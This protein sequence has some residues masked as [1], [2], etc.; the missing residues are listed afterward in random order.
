MCDSIRLRNTYEAI[1]DIST[2]LGAVNGR[3]KAIIWIGGRIPFNP[4]VDCGGSVPLNAAQASAISFMH[5][6]A[7]RAATRNNVAIYSVD[8]LALTPEPG[9]PFTNVLTL[10]GL[11]ALRSVA[12]DTGGQA[13]VSTNRFSQAFEQIVR[14]N[15]SYYLFGYYPAREWPDGRFHTITVRVKRPGLTV[16]ARRGY[17]APEP[18]AKS[19]AASLTAER[20]PVDVAQAL[21]SPLPTNGLTIDAFA[22]PFKGSGERGLVL[23]GARL[24]GADLKLDA[25]DRV[26]IALLTIDTSG[27]VTQGPRKAFTLNLR[28]E[29]RAAVA[30]EGFH[31]FDRLELPVGRH[32]VRLAVRQPGGAIGSIVTHV[33]VEEF[34]KARLALSGIVISSASTATD[35]IL[36]GDPRL[37]EVLSR[38]PT[39]RRRFER[40]DTLTAFA[41]IY[42]EPGT[43]PEDVRLTATLTTARKSQV[44][45][46]TGTQLTSEAGRVG[47]TLRLP[48]AELTPGEYVW[49]M[50]AR[51]GRRTASRQVL[52]TI[53]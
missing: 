43:R 17:Y 53:E 32:E 24:R 42:T 22:A 46:D 6:D 35:R 45:R 51:V 44:R 52:F 34:S 29:T 47:Y 23:I 26:E 48:L 19:Q 10:N 13:V 8:P 7:I 16:R 27:T 28:E 20:R 50:E 30:S 4:L 14:D 15:S 12:E 3:R 2:R 49:T 41:E 1:E 5:R 9:N 21:R 18:N 36:Q 40:N 39:S 11:A 25:E 37:I 33:E 31:Y 38:N